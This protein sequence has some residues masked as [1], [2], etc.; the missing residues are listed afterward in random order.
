MTPFCRASR[1]SRSGR[2]GRWGAG[3]ATCYM[4]TSLPRQKNLPFKEA[5]YGCCGVL[6]AATCYMGTSLPR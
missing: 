3:V 1:T 4:G 2:S 5:G 6:G